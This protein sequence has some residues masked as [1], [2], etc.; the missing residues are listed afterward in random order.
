M[1]EFIQAIGNQLNWQGKIIQVPSGHLPDELGIPLRTE[2]NIIVD[3]KRI[4]EELGYR[5]IFSFKEGLKK[6]IDWELSNMPM[7]I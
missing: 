4:R 6:T 3:S 5:E 1:L 7:D 2:Q